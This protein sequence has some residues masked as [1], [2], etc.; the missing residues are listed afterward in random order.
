MTMP[1]GFVLKESKSIGTCG[2]C[3]FIYNESCMNPFAFSFKEKVLPGY[4]SCVQY[5][6][7]PEGIADCTQ[8]HLEG[9][10]PLTPDKCPGVV[11]KQ[12]ASLIMQDQS[13][14]GRL[15]Q[16]LLGDLKS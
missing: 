2:K 4:I 15:L 12:E 8:C 13:P 6:M 5:D 9:K 3:R 10:C 14:I 7:R 16:N 1:Y 11:S